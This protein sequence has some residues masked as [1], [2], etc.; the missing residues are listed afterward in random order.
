[1]IG[2]AVI[3]PARQGFRDAESLSRHAGHIESIVNS[4]S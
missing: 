2:L 3:V 4:R 1:M